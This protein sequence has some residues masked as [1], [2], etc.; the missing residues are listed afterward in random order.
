ML[1]Y[2]TK[3]NLSGFPE[4]QETKSSKWWGHL[5]AETGLAIFGQRLGLGWTH[6]WEFIGWPCWLGWLGW[7]RSEIATIEICS[8]G[9]PAIKY[10][11]L[12]EAWKFH[13]KSSSSFR[14]MMLQIPM[15]SKCPRDMSLWW[16]DTPNLRLHQRTRQSA[17]ESV[18]Q[19]ANNSMRTVSA[20]VLHHSFQAFSEA[21]KR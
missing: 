16:H 10:S 3:W 18:E 4:M 19:S 15:K 9:A 12:A 5:R 14:D 20:Y 13:V 6:N 7:A 17:V 1:V 8:K 21:P 11:I 2:W